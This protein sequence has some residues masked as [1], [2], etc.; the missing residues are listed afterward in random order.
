MRYWFHHFAFLYRLYSEKIIK[1]LGVFSN[2]LATVASL[3]TIVIVVYNFGFV[4]SQRH[5][6]VLL[7]SQRTLLWI[8]FASFIFRYASNF[9]TVL[10]ERLVWL[11]FTM[12]L[13]IPALLIV[14]N[15]FLHNALWTHPFSELVKKIIVHPYL[16]YLLLLA[17]TF[18]SFSRLVFHLTQKRIKAEAIYIGSFLLL[19]IVGTALLLL[20]NA[21]YRPLSL[22]DA[23]FTATS[24]V[25]VTGLMTIDIAHTF[26]P[27]GQIII[28]M[29]IQMGGIGVV[30][31]SCF[32]ALSFM[33]Q[34]SFRSQF[35]VRDM[36]NE[37]RIGRLFRVLV[38]IIFIT[39]FIEVIG[40]YF[41]F[42][43]VKDSFTNIKDCVFFSAFHSVSAYCNAGISNITNGFENDFL[44]K[45]FSLHW[46]IAILCFIGSIGVPLIANYL[47]LL[48]HFLH[49]VFRMVLFKEK[50]QHIPHVINLNTYIV[51]RFSLILVVASVFLLFVM[52]RN[53]LFTALSEGQKLT[54]SVFISMTARTAG[55]GSFPVHAFTM[56]A[57]LFIMLL[58][59]IGGAPMSTSGGIKVTT[60]AVALRATWYA[61]RGKE[62]VRIR[63]R[64]LDL[65]TVRRAFTIIILYFVWIFISTFLLCYTDPSISVQK[66]FF[67]ATSAITTCGLSMGI[68]PSLSAAGKIIITISMYVGRIGVLSFIYGLTKN[69]ESARYEFPKENVLLG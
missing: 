50:Y 4:I 26:T 45:N 56:P 47:R 32:L 10:K 34:A 48:K 69:I 19:I 28:L 64:E 21:T 3:A 11:D 66:L 40:A 33:G 5:T 51:I 16:N 24:A 22:P 27:T 49:N 59:F 38:Q 14:Q 58:M 43:D 2:I 57:L 17:L 12:F 42:I 39:F 18:V 55:F 25:C 63:N 35:M 8:F 23:L 52:E 37:N 67:E 36:L 29:L 20:P 46:I 44:F 9:K 68:T 54:E 60:A 65:T 7:D 62:Q 15:S 1:T 31:F 41:I 30:T 13:L 53:H 61:L 6:T